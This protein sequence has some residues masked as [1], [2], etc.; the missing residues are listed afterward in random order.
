MWKRTMT[1]M[2]V[3]M[4]VY[5]ISYAVF[6]LALGISFFQANATDFMSLA[7]PKGCEGVLKMTVGASGPGVLTPTKVQAKEVEKF[8]AHQVELARARGERE[9]DINWLLA[10]MVT[11]AQHQDSVEFAKPLKRYDPNRN[12][13]AMIAP[14]A[15]NDN[16]K[17]FLHDALYTL[18]FTSVGRQL[19]EKTIVFG[20]HNKKLREKWLSLDVKEN[21]GPRKMGDFTHI[22]K[23]FFEED[24]CALIRVSK[25]LTLGVAILVF[26]HELSH[27]NDYLNFNVAEIAWPLRSLVTEHQAFRS[28]QMFAQ[29]L[30]NLFPALKI[31]VNESGWYPYFHDMSKFSKQMV[32]YYKVPQSDIDTYVKFH[33]WEVTPVMRY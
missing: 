11:M 27:A 15:I 23:G 6:L 31:F 22:F 28:E 4:K 25:D 8:W 1:Q 26:Y 30:V 7:S 33:S 12:Y 5:T 14:W 13:N 20:F 21:L 17:S 3:K 18:S 19:L 16:E 29:E 32:E 10:P 24:P 9:Y 2:P